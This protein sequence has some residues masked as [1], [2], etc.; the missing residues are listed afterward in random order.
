[1]SPEARVGLATVLAFVLLLGLVLFLREQEVIRPRGM[2]LSIIFQ[3]A[4]GIEVGAPVRL[5]GVTV[6]RVVRTD[7]DPTNQ[8]RVTILV[9]RGVRIPEGSRFQIAMTGFLGDRF[10]QITPGP[11]SAPSLPAGIEVQGEEPFT[12]EGVAQRVEALAD[13]AQTL[14]DHLNALVGDPA[15]RAQLQATLRSAEAATV[16]ARRAAE[17]VERTTRRLEGLV[18]RDVTLAAGD[19]RRMSVTLA[20]TAEALQAFVRQ[21]TGDGQLARDIRETAA[22]ARR[23]SRRAEQMA[24]DLQ[25]VVNPENARAAQRTLE[26]ARATVQEAREVVRRA[27]AVVQRVS[28]VV[29]R[30][31]G[32]LPDGL[33]TLRTL[34][35]VEYDVWVGGPRAGHGLTL[36]VFPD[37]PRFY[38]LGLHDIGGTGGLVLQVGQ[39]LSADLAWRAGVF[40]SQV[41]VGLDYR[42]GPALGMGLDLYNVNQPT[43]D[44]VARYQVTPGWRLSLGARNVLRQPSLLVG[45]GFTF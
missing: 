36:A 22:A 26:E 23:T 20:A 29:E 33:L 3:N 45:V 30:V 17:S 39:R 5:A 10:V 40:D 44:L 12:V 18:A 41:G 21:T 34:A 24:A 27:G 31:G 6:G 15:L 25:R 38:R 19:L 42:L 32:A 11:P 2:T 37:A 1:M 43:L 28:G 9:E 35:R 16:A 8:A 7:L 13:R 4:A 14:L